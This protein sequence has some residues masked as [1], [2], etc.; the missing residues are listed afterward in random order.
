MKSIAILKAWIKRWGPTGELP[1]WDSIDQREA[2]EL[3]GELEKHD[4]KMAYIE[5]IDF[6]IK[7]LR[8]GR[9]AEFPPMWFTFEEW[10]KE[11]HIGGNPEIPLADAF[12]EYNKYI[13]NWSQGKKPNEP[14]NQPLKFD[15]WLANNKLMPVEWEE[16]PGFWW[17]K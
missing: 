6:Q 7:Q 10:S 5:F 16:L 3:L 9:N 15:E 17:S 1:C 2:L 14:F 8:L 13:E 11:N 4:Y 12:T